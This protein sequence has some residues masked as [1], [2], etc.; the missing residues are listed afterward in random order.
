MVGVSYRCL[1]CDMQCRGCLGI[2]VV[3]IWVSFLLLD[4]IVDALN[5]C[6][7]G[8]WQWFSVNGYAN[9]STAVAP[10]SLL[11][12]IK[13]LYGDISSWMWNQSGL[14]KLYFIMVTGLP[15]TYYFDLLAHCECRIANA[16]TICL[17]L[18]AVTVFFTTL[19]LFKAAGGVLLQMAPSG[20]SASALNK[21]LRQVDLSLTHLC[22]LNDH[23]SFCS[24]MFSWYWVTCTLC[25]YWCGVN[26]DI[27]GEN[28][29]RCDRMLRGSFL[30]D[31]ARFYCGDF[32]FT[33]NFML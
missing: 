3:D 18:V 7:E 25:I 14:F 27:S 28:G 1:C 5:I 10:D 29:W 30:G 15:S 8:L 20:T 23:C 9:T 31:G 12:L 32:T 19:P 13:L 4:Y 26:W 17:G 11:W 33:G 16:E 21:C 24:S 2:L 22:D 6:V